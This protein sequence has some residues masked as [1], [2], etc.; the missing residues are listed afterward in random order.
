MKVR[1]QW[2]ALALGCLL[3]LWIFQNVGW[4]ETTFGWRELQVSPPTDLGS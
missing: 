4:E 2:L 3:F 1:L